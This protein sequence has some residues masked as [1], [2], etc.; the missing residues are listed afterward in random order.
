F[1]SGLAM[2]TTTCLAR[3]AINTDT[4]RD[5][6]LLVGSGFVI[7]VASTTARRSSEQ[8]RQAL[9]AEAAT[10]ERERLARSIHDSVLQVLARV[11]R[12]GAEVGG[13][14]GEIGKLAGEQ[15]VALRS[16]VAAAPPESNS[17]GTADLRPRLQLLSTGRVQVS[18]PGT[19]VMLPVLAVV[20]LTSLV[21]EALS[22]VD[23]HAG[24]EARAWVLLEDLGDEVVISV[25]DDGVG[26]DP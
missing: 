1:L 19:P 8:L 18:A 14:A 23:K 11:R 25:R 24:D 4:V 5:A 9:R 21:R 3:G 7:G 20:E 17:E 6:V 10:A 13:E 16:L 26:M 22:N 2:S 15:E 12:R